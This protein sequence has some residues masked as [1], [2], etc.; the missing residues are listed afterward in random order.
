MGI[1]RRLLLILMALLATGLADLRA[2]LRLQA[3]LGLKAMPDQDWDPLQDQGLAGL[4]LFTGTSRGQGLILDLSHSSK[5]DKVFSQPVKATTTDLSLGVYSLFFQ[6]GDLSP[7]AAGGV[8]AA[9]GSVTAGPTHKA[10]GM[11]FWASAGVFFRLS[12]HTVIDLNIRVSRARL[13]FDQRGGLLSGGRTFRVGI[14]MELPH[15][16]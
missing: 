2:E 15:R 5:S 6:P 13:I 4:T 12:P 8:S 9:Y 1:P 14:G 11:G 16:D 10:R 7:Y 3:Q